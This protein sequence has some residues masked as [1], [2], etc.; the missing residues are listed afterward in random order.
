M[1]KFIRVS[2]GWPGI[3]RKNKRNGG[4]EQVVKAMAVRLSTPVSMS[5]K[6]RKDPNQNSTRK[7][8]EVK[9]SA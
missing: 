8:K 5:L 4:P 6:G 7:A 2:W 1:V 9:V 3:E